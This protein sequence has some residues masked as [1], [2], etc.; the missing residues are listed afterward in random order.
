MRPYLI[1]IMTMALSLASCKEKADVKFTV[2]PLT[3]ADSALLYGSRT[4]SSRSL[5]A[6][7]LTSARPE[8]TYGDEPSQPDVTDPYEDYDT[9]RRRITLE[10]PEKQGYT[11]ETESSA[12]RSA[13]E[14]PRQARSS[15]TDAAPRREEAGNQGHEGRP[16]G[17]DTQS[18][19]KAATPEARLRL[20]DARRAVRDAR[21][22]LA[23]TDDPSRQRALCNKLVQLTGEM[24]K[25]ARAAGD[26]ES[27]EEARA[28]QMQYQPAR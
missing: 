2:E 27:Y 23:S 19:A 26:D 18:A 9:A 11:G 14:H 24:M 21:H 5:D 8:L 16:A 1:C 13:A 7:T 25:A 6:D 4:A 22:E 15:W 17:A 28:L 20:Y 3:Q 12:P 10:V